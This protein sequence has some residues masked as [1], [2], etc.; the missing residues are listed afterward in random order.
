MSASG[1]CAEREV[2]NMSGDQGYGNGLRP[3]EKMESDS[4]SACDGKR[5]SHRDV[6]FG[7]DSKAGG[8]LR[9]VDGGERGHASAMASLEVVGKGKLQAA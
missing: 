8:G 7:R 3:H 4:F 5:L 9:K 2:L 6:H 1:G